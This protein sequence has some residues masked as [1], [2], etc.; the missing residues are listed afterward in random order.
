M[1]ALAGGLH[2][3]H[4]GG[5]FMANRTVT[6]STWSGSGLQRV[7]DGDDSLTFTLCA[8]LFVLLFFDPSSRGTGARAAESSGQ[9]GAAAQG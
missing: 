3:R 8:R 1:A 5:S 7:R 6:V 2:L 9:I 4:E